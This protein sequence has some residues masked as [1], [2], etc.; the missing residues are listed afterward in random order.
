MKIVI[1]AGHSNTD[2]GAVSGKDSESKLV[3]QF[4]NALRTCLLDLGIETVSDGTGELNLPLG[5]A[6]KLA[7]EAKFALEIHMNASVNNTANGVETIALPKDKTIAQKISIA[8]AEGLGGL[9]IRGVNGWI[10]QSQSARGKLGY[11][12]AG[13]LILELCFI[14]N[15][16]E[17]AKYKAS[18]WAAARKLA[19]V[20][21]EHVGK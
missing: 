15:P 1:T 20:I 4:R 13:G 21:A 3:T 18:Y 19:N 9:K 6:I 17:L 8:V 7:K 2:P 14:S 12:N 11:I 10:D 5:D 16:T